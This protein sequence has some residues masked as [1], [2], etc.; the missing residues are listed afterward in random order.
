M[1]RKSQGIQISFS[2]KG[3]TARISWMNSVLLFVLCIQTTIF[4]F[5]N[6]FQKQLPLCVWIMYNRKKQLSLLQKCINQAINLPLLT[7]QT[8]WPC[9]HQC[10]VLFSHT[11]HDSSERVYVSQSAS[12]AA[13]ELSALHST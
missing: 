10:L 7:P 4:C 9:F 5:L 11:S 12:E 8:K 3:K 13:H 2:K 6:I 1:S